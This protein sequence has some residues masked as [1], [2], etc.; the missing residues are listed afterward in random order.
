MR[1]MLDGVID[2]GTEFVKAVGLLHALAQDPQVVRRD[3]LMYGNPEQDGAAGESPCQR[4]A[5]L[6]QEPL[7]PVVNPAASQV[8]A[9]ALEVGPCIPMDIGAHGDLLPGT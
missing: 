2:G 5:D 3:A 4:A 8:D 6:L 9:Q 1:C 7:P